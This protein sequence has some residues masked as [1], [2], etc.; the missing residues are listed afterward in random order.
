MSDPVTPIELVVVSDGVPVEVVDGL[1]GE[2]G[3]RSI[4]LRIL[5]DVPREVAY[6]RLVGVFADSERSTPL[7]HTAAA[8][9][10]VGTVLIT[11]SRQI[12]TYR[13]AFMNG[14]SIVHVQSGSSI[15][16]DVLLARVRG[17]LLA[18]GDLIAACFGAYRARL[19]PSEH[20]VLTQI[21]EGRTAAEIAERTYFS[22]RHVRRL[23]HSI[24]VKAETD[25]RLEAVAYFRSELATAGT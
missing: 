18:P 20:L 3:S 14:A 12:D 5:P 4:P 8:D 25:D 6:T 10:L 15:L 24:L 7:F 19:T 11:D 16:A 21:A 13:R 23:L 22:D 17:E 2:F 1:V 9:H